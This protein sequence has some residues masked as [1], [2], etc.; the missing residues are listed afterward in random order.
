MPG[1]LY[2]EG[3]EVMLQWIW[4]SETAKPET[5]SLHLFDHETDRYLFPLHLGRSVPN[6]GA[7]AWSVVVPLEKQTSWRRC[8]VG[9]SIEPFEGHRH[10]SSNPPVRM[11]GSFA[12]ISFWFDSLNNRDSYGLAWRVG[13]PRGPACVI[14]GSFVC[15]FHAACRTIVA[16]FSSSDGYLFSSG[17]TG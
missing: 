10:H 11:V 1:K 3:S 9:M 8:Y 17:H 15:R 2:L 13:D 14:N 7:F 6:T 16:C 4:L 5:V 12:A